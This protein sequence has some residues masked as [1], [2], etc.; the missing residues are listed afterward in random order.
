MNSSFENWKRY[1]VTCVKA[2]K[3]PYQRLSWKDAGNFCK[4]GQSRT[5][6]F[7]YEVWPRLLHFG[8]F[9]ALDW[10]ETRKYF[11]R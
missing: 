2:F 9:N 7:N 1:S 5:F 4:Y 3:E 10:T 6:N 8:E 11:F